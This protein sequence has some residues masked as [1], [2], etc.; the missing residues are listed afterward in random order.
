MRP[1]RLANIS[2]LGCQRYFLTICTSERRE[3][4]TDA[5]LVDVVWLQFSR[6]AEA[7]AFAV[8]AYCFTPDHL[9]LLVEGTSDAADLCSFVSTAKHRGAYAARKW[10]RGRLWQPGYYE[11]VLR[12]GDDALDVNRYIL[13]NPVRAGLARSPGDYPFLGGMVAVEELE[14]AASWR[15]K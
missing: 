9:H 15:P 12:E 14:I 3:C 5:R 4:F 2:Y 1:R 11:R 8:I 7:H 13:Q 10:I 6:Q